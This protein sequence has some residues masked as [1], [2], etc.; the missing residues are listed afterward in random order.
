ML[1]IYIY[2]YIYIFKKSNFESLFMVKFSV[3]DQSSTFNKSLVLC[4]IA[5]LM[6]RFFWVY[7]K[8][9]SVSERKVGF[10]LF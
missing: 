6:G 8:F 9:D 2:I 3:L 7:S 5:Y 1:S 4:S 10:K